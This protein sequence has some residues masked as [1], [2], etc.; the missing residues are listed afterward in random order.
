MEIGGNT[1]NW[2]QRGAIGAK[3]TRREPAILAGNGRGPKA[4]G[5]TWTR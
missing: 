3:S 4:L 5:V 1:G 2:E